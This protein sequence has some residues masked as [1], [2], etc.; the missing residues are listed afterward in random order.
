MN[1]PQSMPLFQPLNGGAGQVFGVQHRD[2]FGDGFIR[3][4]GTG[5]RD[6]RR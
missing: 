1:N 3:V 5:L 6:V 2:Q 4:A